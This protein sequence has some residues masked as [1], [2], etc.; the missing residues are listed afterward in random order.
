M[1]GVERGGGVL[2][3]RRCHCSNGTNFCAMD[4]RLRKK[5]KF[6]TMYAII[7]NERCVMLLVESVPCRAGNIVIVVVAAA[8]ARDWHVLVFP[9]SFMSFFLLFASIGQKSV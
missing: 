1:T 3:S 9:L 8:G 4:S 7:F 2:T 6:N 5:I